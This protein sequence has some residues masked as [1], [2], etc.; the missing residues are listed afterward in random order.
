M[1][2]LINLKYKGDFYCLIYYDSFITKN[3]IYSH[4]NVCKYKDVYNNVMSSEDTKILE[5]NQYH[6]FDQRAFI[7]H[8]D[9]EYLLENIYP[10]K[11][12]FERS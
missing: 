2:I 6:E 3:P 9:F 10:C 7:V 1:T 5:F 11:N 12:M 4:K 8:L